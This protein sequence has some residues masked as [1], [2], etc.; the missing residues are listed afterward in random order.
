MGGCG[1]CG[2]KTRICTYKTC[3]RFGSSVRVPYSSVAA[4][5]PSGTT[6]GATLG[7]VPA[8]FVCAGRPAARSPPPPRF[9]ACV[10]LALGVRRA[11]VCPCGAAVSCLP[12]VVCGLVGWVGGCTARWTVMPSRV[13]SREPPP[14][15]CFRMC[16]SGCV[17]GPSP[18]TAPSPTPSPWS[19]LAGTIP[20]QY[21]HNSTV[22]RLKG[23]AGV[24]RG[25]AVGLA[26]QRSGLGA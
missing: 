4:I 6:L 11:A 20:A 17:L 7:A 2:G 23:R 15:V 21:Q 5:P 18:A 9:G 13:P 16:A 19:A 25:G 10:I 8:R 12:S 26:A 24:R 3:S 14:G 1:G 22:R